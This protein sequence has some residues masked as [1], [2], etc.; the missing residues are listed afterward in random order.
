M[1]NKSY[2]AEGFVLIQ[3]RKHHSEILLFS[4]FLILYGIA[5]PLQVRL[6]V[7]NQTLFNPNTVY[8]HIYGVQ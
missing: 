5:Q 3:E 4:L 1:W 6:S 2:H 7:D 8:I